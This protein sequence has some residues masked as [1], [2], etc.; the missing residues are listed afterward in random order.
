MHTYPSVNVIG[1]FLSNPVVMIG[2][3][4]LKKILGGRTGFPLQVRP[5]FLPTRFGLSTAIPAAVIGRDELICYG[6]T[7]MMLSPIFSM[8]AF[9]RILAF[10]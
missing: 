10:A 4:Y 7:C 8:T 5:R 1:S 2:E 9:F 6:L 3:R